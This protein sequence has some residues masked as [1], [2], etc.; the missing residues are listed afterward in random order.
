MVE[1][2]IKEKI[3][4]VIE[5]VL[6][7]SGEV[8]PETKMGVHAKW[9]SLKHVEIMM[10]LEKELTIKIDPLDFHEI[11]SVQQIYTYIEKRKK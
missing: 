4:I 10:N 2:N 11:L 1:N 3:V 6:G 8:G 5:K 9:T 7:V